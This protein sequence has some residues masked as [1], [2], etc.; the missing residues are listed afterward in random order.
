MC[1]DGCGSVDGCRVWSSP[2]PR[3]DSTPWGCHVWR[4]V[5]PHSPAR[6]TLQQPYVNGCHPLPLQYPTTTRHN[7]DGQPNE[8]NPPTHMAPRVQRN[9]SPLQLLHHSRRRTG[10]TRSRLPPTPIHNTTLGHQHPTVGR[11]T[12]TFMGVNGPRFPIPHPPR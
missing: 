4:L 9:R 1:L 6:T 12:Q 8:L 3:A 5:D 7:P 11:R 2:P 10:Q